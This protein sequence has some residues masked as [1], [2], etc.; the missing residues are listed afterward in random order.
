[1][2]LNMFHLSYWKNKTV[3]CLLL[4]KLRLFNQ[5][6]YISLNC[7]TKRRNRNDYTK[8]EDCGKDKTDLQN[9]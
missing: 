8:A 2:D 3:S 7:L 1:M 4:I 9:N 5:I 6:Y